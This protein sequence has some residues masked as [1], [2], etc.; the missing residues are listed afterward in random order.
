[1]DPSF[2]CL[3]LPMKKEDDDTSD[4][5]KWL[6]DYMVIREDLGKGGFCKVKAADVLVHR[7]GKDKVTGEDKKIKGT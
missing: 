5:I 2:K 6:E 7:D 3:A 1:M 4:G